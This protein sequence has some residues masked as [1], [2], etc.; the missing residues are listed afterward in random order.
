MIQQNK[1]FNKLSKSMQKSILND[2]Y[3]REQFRIALSR[4]NNK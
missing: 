2:W 4:R 3:V 1:L